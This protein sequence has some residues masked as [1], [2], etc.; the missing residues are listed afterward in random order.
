MLKDNDNFSLGFSVDTESQSPSPTSG[1][2]RMQAE[3]VAN[4]MAI[5]RER[6]KVLMECWEQLVNHAA[7]GSR[8]RE[9]LTLHEYVPW[10]ILDVGETYSFT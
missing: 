2:S 8:S 3:L 9:F 7:S 10:R 6:A 5:D 4:L 1:K